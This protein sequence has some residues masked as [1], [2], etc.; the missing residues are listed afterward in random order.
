MFAH[1][2]I[3]RDILYGAVN[4]G[5]SLEVLC[6]KLNISA[7]QL[8]EN[9]SR[10]DFKTAMKAW[11][12]SVK[13][14]QD[15]LLG[16]HLG[17]GTHATI[18]G[19]VGYLMQ[20]SAT[21]EEAF[22]QVAKYSSV[23]TDMFSYRIVNDSR[24]AITLEFAPAEMWVKL[25]ASSARQAVDQA[26]A[27]TLHVF[28]LL[29]GKRIHP[30]RVEMKAPRPSHIS[31]YERVFSVQTTFRSRKNVLTFRR[32]D[33][34]RPILSYDESL[35]KSFE[36]LLQK[37]A[38]KEVHL[39]RDRLRTLILVEFTGQVPA[40]EIAASAF[41]LTT[42]SLQRKLEAEGTSYREIASAIKEEVARELLASKDTKVS[43]VARLLGYSEASSFRRAFKNWTNETPQTYR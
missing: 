17:E 42:R 2:P 3:I 35:F 26:M 16:L 33:L 5:A 29:A 30:I 18:L 25:S 24:D 11:D 32:V 27:G 39:M 12:L 37:K 15:P 8:R 10:V 23:A 22:R 40:I 34:N 19:M 14:S 38:N 31:E 36:S 41:N 6:E 9:D 7:E 20:T 21:L 28:Q 43:E 13:Y 4:R 1:M